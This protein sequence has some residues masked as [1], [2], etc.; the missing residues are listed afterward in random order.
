M[1][2]SGDGAGAGGGG[3]RGGLLG[4]WSIWPS[5]DGPHYG[6]RLA[7]LLRELATK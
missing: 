4:G 3:G 7:P 2:E 6:C 5:S 1:R